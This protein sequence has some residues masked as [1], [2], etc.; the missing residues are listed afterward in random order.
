MLDSIAN[1]EAATVSYCTQD[2]HG[3]RSIPAGAITAAQFVFTE[4]FISIA[5]QIN[6][7]A[8]NLIEGDY[9]GE[10]GRFHFF[11]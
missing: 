9:G 2:I 10:L 11:Y 5:G 4:G 7:P 8:F 1:T 3:A 6:Q